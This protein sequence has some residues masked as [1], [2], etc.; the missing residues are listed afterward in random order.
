MAHAYWFKA[1]KYGY[2][3]APATWEGWAATA[4]YCL[5]VWVSAAILATHTASRAI[6]LSMTSA[7]VI[8]TIALVVIAI[9]KTEGRAGWNAAARQNS[10]KND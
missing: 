6:L 7:M 8:A 3:G 10:R 4:A 5:V 2:G 9:R 1:K